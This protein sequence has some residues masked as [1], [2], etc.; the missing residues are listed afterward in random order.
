MK[1]LIMYLMAGVLGGIIA[2]SVFLMAPHEQERNRYCSAHNF[3]F[4][5]G[6]YIDCEWFDANLH[7]CYV[8]EIM[9]CTNCDEERDGEVY[10]YHEEHS[11]DWK[12]DR[13]EC[14]CGDFYK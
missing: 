10:T 11:Y 13:F 6:K 4:D 1:K 14:E 5:H 9:K 7:T 12:G 2:L 3:V 8:L